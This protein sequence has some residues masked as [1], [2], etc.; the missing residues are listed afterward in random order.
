MKRYLVGLVFAFGMLMIG[1]A[2]A[3]LIPGTC[4]WYSTLGEAL[5]EDRDKGFE[6]I[7]L[8]ISLLE[9][10]PVGQHFSNEYAFLVVDYVF[11]R[12]WNPP[13][14]EGLKVMEACLRDMGHI[15]QPMH[16]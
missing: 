4:P 12:P 3:N 14:V 15:K 16:W 7:D 1:S 11:T 8:K 5:A 9:N 13:E 2:N 6:A 10:N